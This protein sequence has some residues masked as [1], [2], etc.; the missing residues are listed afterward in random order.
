MPSSPIGP[1]RRGRTT[2]GPAAGHEGGQRLDGGAL[3][4]E[5]VGQGVGAVGQGRMA[6]SAMTHSP[7][8]V[9]PMGTMS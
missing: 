7:A 1:C 3:H 4:L 8:R 9:M 5:G 2:T 6:A